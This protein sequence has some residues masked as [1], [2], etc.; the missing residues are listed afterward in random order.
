[1]STRKAAASKVAVAFRARYE[2]AGDIAARASLQRGLPKG[3]WFSAASAAIFYDFRTPN[4]FRVWARRHGL[5]TAHFGGCARYS[6]ADIDAQMT[7][8]AGPVLIHGDI[9][10]E[11]ERGA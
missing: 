11:T 5:V 9:L 10:K 1:M 3:P 4:A 6:R 2:Q 8:K 7:V